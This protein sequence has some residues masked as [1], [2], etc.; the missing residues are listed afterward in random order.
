MLLGSQLGSAFGYALEVTDLNNDGW[1]SFI[2]Y[3]DVVLIHFFIFMC[4]CKSALQ[5]YVMKSSCV[6]LL[7]CV[8][9]VWVS[10]SVC[11]CSTFNSKTVR[12]IVSTYGV[13]HFA[14]NANSLNCIHLKV[15]KNLHMWKW[16]AKWENCK[17]HIL[18]QHLWRAVLLIIFLYCFLYIFLYL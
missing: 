4:F 1:A 8:Y 16:L 3:K 9:C 14:A 6:S 10:I 12:D 7:V 2:L 15:T 5:K 17:K 18:C 11:L 13:T